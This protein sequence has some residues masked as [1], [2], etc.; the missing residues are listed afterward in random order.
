MEFNLSDISEN[1]IVGIVTGLITASLLLVIKHLFTNSFMPWYRQIMFKGTDLSGSW[2]SVKVGQ[3]ILLEINQ[4]CEVL[5][6]KATVQL[7]SKNE[8]N[9][10]HL[11]DIRTFDVSGEISERFVS[12]TFKHTDK[13]RLGL[14]ALLLQVDGDGTK[15]SGQ[16]CWYAPLTATVNSGN[17]V[18]HR[19]ETRANEELD[20]L[21]KASA[22]LKK[23]ADEVEQS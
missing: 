12:L 15:L 23:K 10:L 4:S 19:N 11:D 18:F 16:G 8:K 20:N 1:I 6:G 5:T 3:K 22:L 9:N 14:V 21:K 7:H 2:Y 17:R 13:T